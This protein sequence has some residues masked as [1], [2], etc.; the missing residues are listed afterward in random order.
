MSDG[1]YRGYHNLLMSQW[2]SSDGMLPKSDKEL[3][4]LSGLFGRWPEFKSEILENFEESDGRIINQVQYAEW[5]RA[6]QVSEKKGRRNPDSGESVE[7]DSQNVDSMWTHARVN[8]NVSVPVDKNIDSLF[9]LENG[10]KRDE[11]A[12]EDCDSIAAQCGKIYDAYPRHTAKEAALKAIER[13]LKKKPYLELFSLVQAY[14]SQT[15]K[16]ISSGRLEKKYIPHPATWFNQGRYE[17]DDLK[18]APEYEIVEVSP[19][20]WWKGANGAQ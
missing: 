17:D 7:D 2:Q 3:A 4:R 20:E 8:V 13:A 19:E 18:P 6:K 5:M 11:C 15:D 14:K 16:E 1:A 10:S 12:K 9:G